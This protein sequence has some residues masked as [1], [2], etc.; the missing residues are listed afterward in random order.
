M[1]D[2]DQAT[3]I[4]I[5]DRLARLEGLLLGL[6]NNISQSQ[7]QWTSSQRRVELLEQ[8]MGRLEAGQV[9]KEDMKELTNKVEALIGASKE[10]SGK[11]N[12]LNWAVKNAAPWVAILLSVVALRDVS[13]QRQDLSPA[14]SGQQ[15]PPAVSRPS[16]PLADQRRP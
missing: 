10:S 12:V 11:A 3:T 7:L 4:G 6:Q 1:N 5:I 14:A 8:R 15:P 16:A 9:T 13:A 2:A